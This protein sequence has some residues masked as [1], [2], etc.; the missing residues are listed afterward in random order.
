MGEVMDFGGALNALREGK[1]V[2]RTGWNN[3]SIWLELQIPDE[4]SKMTKPYIY[5]VKGD[6]KFPCDLSCE[7]ILGVDWVIVA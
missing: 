5:M 7:S 3:S 6:D 4:H 1:K 2:T